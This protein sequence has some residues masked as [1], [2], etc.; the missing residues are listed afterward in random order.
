MGEQEDHL[1]S[2]HG[3]LIFLLFHVY[4]NL[5]H[6]A[7]TTVVTPSEEKYVFACKLSIHPTQEAAKN[8]FL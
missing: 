6:S 1:V 4:D 5:L 8:I 3:V 7:A 2:V